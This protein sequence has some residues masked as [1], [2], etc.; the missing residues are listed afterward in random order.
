[1]AKK[2]HCTEE[3]IHRHPISTTLSP[4]LTHVLQVVKLAQEDRY[5][6]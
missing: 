4:I 5:F 2:P 6:Q 3:L 1:M